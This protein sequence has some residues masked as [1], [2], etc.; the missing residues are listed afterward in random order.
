MSNTTTAVTENPLYPA[1]FN[2]NEEGGFDA[3]FRD[4]PEA[5]ASGI[6]FND[7]V[8]RAEESLLAAKRAFEE[9]NET[10]P[11]PSRLMSGDVVIELKLDTEE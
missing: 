3:I 9:D 4:V 5:N 2:P 6:S 7:T 8:E 11:E 1:M 10:M